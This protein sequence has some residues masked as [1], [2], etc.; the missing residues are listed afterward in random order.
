MCVPSG[1][2][3]DGSQQ[4]EQTAHR[5][6]VEYEV[7]QEVISHLTPDLVTSNCWQDETWTQLNSDPK[8]RFETCSWQE[9][10][11]DGDD[12]V[13]EFDPI[14]HERD[15]DPEGEHVAEP[16]EEQVAGHL[17]LGPAVLG[18]AVTAC[19]LQKR[20]VIKNEMK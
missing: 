14:G 8:Y 13:R 3:G 16:V 5:E 18:L 20:E 17:L 9:T 7:T 1:N 19:N 12:V 6:P 10:G 11:D 2:G 15:D 4:T